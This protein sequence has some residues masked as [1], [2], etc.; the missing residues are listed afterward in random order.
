MADRDDDRGR[1]IAHLRCRAASIWR[2]AV[3]RHRQMG[4]GAQPGLARRP[5]AGRVRLA[6]RSRLVLG[7][8]TLHLHVHLDGEVR[9]GLRGA[10]RHP[11]RRRRPGQYPSRRIA[12]P[13]HHVR[14]DVRRPFHCHR[15]LFRGRVRRP[16]VADRP[17]IQRLG[18]ADV[19]GVSHHPARLRADVLPLPAG[20]LVVL[21]H[22]RAAASRHGRRRGR[23]NRPGPSGPGHAQSGRPRRTQSARLDPDVVAGPDRGRVLRPFGA[24][25]HAA[26]RACVSPSSSASC[27]H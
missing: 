26:G 6:C 21:S 12:P 11:C 19:A 3:D 14:P 20:R 25:D 23:R 9:C 10:H 5:R 27:C 8:G 15:M 1:D 18:S 24:R 13:R 16:D 7:A 22:R 2:R 17:A 4:G